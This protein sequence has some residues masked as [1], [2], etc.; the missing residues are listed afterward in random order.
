MSVLPA[1]VAATTTVVL[2]WGLL[3]SR[4]SAVIQDVPNARS[5]HATPTPRIG[6]IGLMAGVAAGWMLCAEAPAWWVWLPLLGLVIVSLLD[7]VRGM[8]VPIRLVVHLAAAALLV[9]GSGLWSGQGEIVGLLVVFITAWM[10]NLFNFMD[11]SDGLAGGMALF[12]FLFCGLAAQ[13]E[14]STALAMQC[15][16]VSAAAVGFLCFNFPPA[17]IF[18]GDAGSIPLGF[19]VCAL[20]LAGWQQ[21]L[22]TPWFPLLVFSPFVMDATVTLIRRTLRGARITEAHRE[23]YYQR[24]IQMGHSHLKVALWAYAWMF[25]VGTSA[26]WVGKQAMGWLFAAWIAVYAV[27]MFVLDRRWKRLMANPS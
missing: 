5:L 10:T 11:G 26:L 3:R 17:R 1:V 16:V 15:S 13:L 21:G 12:G 27:A 19:L 24:A 18:M 9:I 2:L 23:H 14:G 25:A 8:P 22:W 4:L 20:G 7:D 6:G